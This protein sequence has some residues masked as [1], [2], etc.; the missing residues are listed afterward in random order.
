MVYLHVDMSSHG[1]R[2]STASYHKKKYQLRARIVAS[3]RRAT[4][5]WNYDM[6]PPSTRTSIETICDHRYA[7][8][9]LNGILMCLAGAPEVTSQILEQMVASCAMMEQVIMRYDMQKHNL[10]GDARA[11]SIF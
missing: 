6:F 1:M 11:S 9:A 7:Y 10:H 4:R 5:K 2:R 8:I 3:S